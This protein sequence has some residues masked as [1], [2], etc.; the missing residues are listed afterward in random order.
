MR[1]L[2]LFMT[3]GMLAIAAT[4]FAAQAKAKD[5]WVTGH[6]D[7]FDPVSKSVVVKQGTHEL[8]FVLAGDA[9][10][11]Q[12]KT[13]LQPS[14]LA[15]DVGREVKVRYTMNAGTRLADRIEVS[16]VATPPAKSAT[17]R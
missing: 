16:E 15:A 10:V 17:K 9:H 6:I 13:S 14:D 3:V 1:R 8:T 2:S 5:A 12:G 11:M 7:R 4:S